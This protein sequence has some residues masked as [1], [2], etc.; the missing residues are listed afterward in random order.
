MLEESE[1][2]EQKP[3]KADHVI[4]LVNGK[5]R[6]ETQEKLP[7]CIAAPETVPD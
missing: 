2:A 1:F 6:N 7:E 5:D 4:E 3:V